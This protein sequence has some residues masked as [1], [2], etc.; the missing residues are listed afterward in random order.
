M[1]PQTLTPA[2]RHRAA[3]GGSRA[4][5]RAPVGETIWIDPAYRGPMA[6]AGLTTLSAVMRTTA[7]RC[8][9]ALVD[10]ENWRIELDGL[11]SGPRGA[12]LKKHHVRGWRH[13][14]RARL[15][16]GPGATP[17]RTEAANVARLER[18]GIAAMRLIAFGER[19]H[20]DGLLE[21][22]VITEELAG[23]TQLDHYLRQRFAPRAER[24]GRD[25]ALEALIGAVADVARRF[26]AAGYNHRDLYCCHFFIRPEAGQQSDVRLI[27]LQRVEQRRWLRRRWIVKDLAQLAYSAPRE[28][29]GCRERIRFLRAYLGVRKLR[30]ED[31]R[32]IRA[33]MAKW[34]RMENHL[35]AHP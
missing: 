8:L 2:A 7:G 9:R 3:P 30:P 28:R 35:G 4:E 26:H 18:D 14:L 21:S 11:P 34:R 22:F 5:V 1:A 31:K 12:Y 13:W 23:Y 27:D 33:V 32:L 16:L 10:R 6:A 29:I 15:G 20:A 25:A 17:G 19:L 24:T